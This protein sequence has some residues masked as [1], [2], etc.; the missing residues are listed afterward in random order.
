MTITLYWWMLPAGLLVIGLMLAG[1]VRSEGGGCY[2]FITPVLSLAV[3][4]IFAA[5]AIGITVGR[6]L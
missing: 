5:A 4:V 6:F 3:F 2:D 1:W